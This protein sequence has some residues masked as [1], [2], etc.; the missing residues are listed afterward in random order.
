VNRVVKWLAIAF[1]VW[2]VVTAPSAAGL[3]VHN[4]GHLAARAAT[5]VST[6]MS[7]I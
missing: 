6:L 4:I 1:V 2:W 3:A 5:S 7:S